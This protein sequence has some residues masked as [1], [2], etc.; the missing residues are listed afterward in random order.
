[1]VDLVD[2]SQLEEIVNFIEKNNHG[3]KEIR[4]MEKDKK[5]LFGRFQ[6]RLRK[7]GLLLKV[8]EERSIGYVEC[9]LLK[10]EQY[11]QVL[12][13]CLDGHVDV[14]L[15]QIFD[16]IR[17]K[18]SDYELDIVL[19]KI[20]KDY[21]Q[22][23]IKRNFI[24]TGFEQMMVKSLKGKKKEK[25]TLARLEDKD[26]S[27]FQTIHD[28]LFGDV[29]WTSERLL[30]HGSPFEILVYKKGDEL[31]G[32][33]VCSSKGRKEEEV[34]FL[35][36]QTRKIKEEL[37]KASIN[38]VLPTCENLLYLLESTSKDQGIFEDLGFQ[39]KET[40]ITFSM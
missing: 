9:M 19:S 12:A 7:G 33:S 37:L 23:F 21:I 18:Y 29:Y 4:Y 2:R 16:Y 5:K 27:V 17:D 24:S 35:Y 3:S 1:M 14:L 15:D 30:E 28:D 25:L 6:E 8:E 38:L 22:Y 10:E 39:E 40:I 26:Y 32:Y 13:I 20:N 36:G 11:I 31:L 34:Y